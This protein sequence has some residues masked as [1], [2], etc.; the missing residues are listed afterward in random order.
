MPATSRTAARPRAGGRSL[1]H[2][3]RRALAGLVTGAAVAAGAALVV[4]PAAP[5]EAADQTVTFTTAGEHPVTVPAGATAMVVEALGGSGGEPRGLALPG[6]TGALVTAELPIT[7]G[8]SYT[9]VVGGNG[10]GPDGGYNGGA[11]GDNPDAASVSKMGGG[12]GATDLRRNGTALSDR[13]L[14]AGGGGGGH[15]W[16]AGGNAGG[17]TGGAGE[18]NPTAAQVVPGAGGGTQSAGGAAG[19][20]YDGVAGTAGSFGAGGLPGYRDAGNNLGGGGG[21]G[22]YGGGGGSPYGSGGAGSS[23][24]DASGINSS[25]SQG[26]RGAAPYLKITFRMQPVAYMLS[27]ISSN[28]IVANGTAQVTA[29]VVLRDIAFNPVIGEVVRFTSTIP[30]QSITPTV[31]HG[32]GTYTAQITATTDVATGYVTASVVGRPDLDLVHVLVQTPGPPQS[33][34]L[35]PSETTFL[36]DGTT[37]VPFALNVFDAW[38]HPVDVAAPPTLSASD[39]ELAISPLARVAE[40]QYT[41]TITSSRVVGP[42]TLSAFQAEHGISASAVV[43]QIAGPAAGLSA[44]LS[45]PEIVADGATTSLLTLGVTDSVGHPIA[46]AAPTVTSDGEQAISSVTD[47]GDGTYTATIAASDTVGVATLTARV[48][49]VDPALVRSVELTQTT[50]PATVLGLALAETTLTADGVSTTTATVTAADAYGHPLA[51]EPITLVSSDPDQRISSITDH[52]DGS[53][54]A[55]VTASTSLGEHT[56]TAADAS[57]DPALTQTATL[58]QIVGAAVSAD[59]VL[60]DDAILADGTSTTTITVTARDGQQHPVPGIDILLSS[61]DPDQRL[62]AFTESAPGVYAATIRSSKTVG[63]STL[64]VTTPAPRVDDTLLA[65][66]AAPPTVLGTVELTQAELEKNPMSP[67]PPAAPKP[68]SPALAAGG[69]AVTGNEAAPAALWTALGLLLA[70]AAAYPLS[71]LSASRWEQ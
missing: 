48:D 7:P 6:G 60:G 55:T 35:L 54:T 40:G 20:A 11:P 4:A 17:L 5:A 45:A 49:T 24:V 68:P 53:Y 44:E 70:G 8:A 43:T 3:G 10:G 2:L 22:Y 19:Q 71:R 61:T 1:F 15:P 39:P 57:V 9:A 64:T 38:G 42:V 52:G 56:I 30:G 58:T 21:G 16:A 13:I 51:D 18:D 62:G 66:D 12:G 25:M 28:S 36:A 14:V 47:H 50:G 41:G 59:I 29:T 69:L 31:D 27:A 37:Q 67:T 34:Q 63:T 33:M 23:Y 32:D 65:E 46:G 26:D